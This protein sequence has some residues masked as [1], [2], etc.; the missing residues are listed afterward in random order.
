ML[1]FSSCRTN[2]DIDGSDG[3][4]E[5][6]KTPD[7]IVVGYDGQ[8][9]EILS[10]SDEFDRIVSGIGE[11][12]DKSGAFGTLNLLAKGLDGLHLSY[13]IRERETFVEFVYTEAAPQG[14]KM[15][16]AGGESEIKDIDVKKIFFP[17]SGS[18]HDIIFIGNDAEYDSYTS[19]GPLTDNTSL[20]TY[21]RELFKE[22]TA[23][24]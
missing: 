7:K 5:F 20:T 14:F 24:G 12:E 16:Q 6:P 4:P 1:L 10:G 15:A 13:E 9:K 3:T 18:Y 8:E 22:D 2:G 17:L 23:A 19:L 11:R 21:V